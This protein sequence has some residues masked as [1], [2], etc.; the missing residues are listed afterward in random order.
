MAIEVSVIVP[1]YNHGLFL[2][3]RLVSILNQ[4]FQNF[5]IIILDDCSTDN[6]KAIIEAFRTNSKVSQVL[7]NTS[8][9][10]STFRQWQKGLSLAKADWIWIAE[11]DDLAD[12]MLLQKLVELTKKNPGCVLAYSATA[13]IDEKGNSLGINNWADD[14][15]RR[16]WK[17]AFNNNGLSE[18]S[19]YLKYKNVIP[20]ASAVLFKK[21]RSTVI[22]KIAASGMRYTGDWIFWMELL[23]HGTICFTPEVLNFQRSHTATTRQWGN[24]SSEIRRIKEYIL[25]VKKAGNITG[26]KIRWQ[27]PHYSWIFMQCRQNVPYNIKTIFVLFAQTFSI[28]FLKTIVKAYD[29]RPVI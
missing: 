22:N 20:N 27:N 12:S 19:N 18:I 2:R 24:V 23:K 4:S 25:A 8:N 11:S 21:E 6:S 7:Y 5:E 26:S 29:N 16:R 9:S 14:L 1:N 28:S 13:H 10:G 17:K 15:C 3:Q